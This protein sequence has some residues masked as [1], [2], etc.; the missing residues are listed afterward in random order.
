MN[1]CKNCGEIIPRYKISRNRYAIYCSRAC[2]NSAQTRYSEE[3]RR[4]VEEHI[5]QVHTRTL[6]QKL[7]VTC[8]GLKRQISIWRSEGY[9]MG[10]GRYAHYSK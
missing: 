2:K 4:Y 5:G 7:N 10:G 9:N 6:A 1:H 8:T 3:V